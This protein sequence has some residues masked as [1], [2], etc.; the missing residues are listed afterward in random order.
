MKALKTILIVLTLFLSPISLLARGAEGGNA[1]GG[2]AEIC[3]SPNRC[4]S[5]AEAG[6]RLSQ[7]DVG[8]E[9]DPA[10][11]T[12]LDKISALFPSFTIRTNEVVPDRETIIPISVDKE[13]LAE[14]FLKRYRKMLI[15]HGEP[16]LAEQV[17]LAGF[18]VGKKTYLFDS[19]NNSD[20]NSGYKAL[21]PG[22][23]RALLLIHELA[24]RRGATQ[25]AAIHFDGTLLDAMKAIENHQP[26]DRWSLI[27][28]ARDAHALF[29]GDVS[30]MAGW[31]SHYLIAELLRFKGDVATSEEIFG[32][33]VEFHTDYPTGVT[34]TYEQLLRARA[35]HPRAATDITK[36]K[37]WAEAFQGRQIIL[38][39]FILQL[40]DQALARGESQFFI[41]NINFSEFV[42]QLG[43]TDRK[44]LAKCGDSKNTGNVLLRNGSAK[45]PG[46][47]ELGFASCELRSEIYLR[48]ANVKIVDKK[49]IWASIQGDRLVN[50]TKPIPCFSSRAGST[51]HIW[52]GL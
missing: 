43:A 51:P 32:S 16:A 4:V 5:L 46:D 42:N 10:T 40:R 36:G 41:N 20:N 1:G 52:C 2:G 7:P 18:S 45:N 22:D 14:L 37:M 11:L 39:R 48:E 9:I 19:D 31:T 3:L 29:N 44:I 27:L 30:V 34:I 21:T 12:A 35:I 6:F 17:K 8:F 38:S 15:E 50:L 24:I 47:D 26:V 23:S 28:A 13:G 25:E 33:A 49:N